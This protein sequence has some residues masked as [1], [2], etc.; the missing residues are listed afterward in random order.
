MTLAL[1]FLHVLAA[2]TWIGG[3]L[4]VALVLVPVVRSQADPALRARLFHQVGVRFR[5]VGW[6]ALLLLLATGLANLW[7]RPYLLTLSRFQW[8]LGLVVLALGLSAL[9]DF[10]LGP[11]AG[12]P[13]ADPA[14]RVW[15][16]W[17]ARINVLVVLIV[18]VLGLALRG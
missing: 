15:A 9:H 2:I 3:M 12:V 16:S 1:R 17:I 8:K 7:M 11:R 10:V 6:V 18:V 14:L 5:V 4:F 13:G